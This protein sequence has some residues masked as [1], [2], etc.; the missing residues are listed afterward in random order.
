MECISSKSSTLSTSIYKFI[1]KNNA[2]KTYSTPYN[3]IRTSMVLFLVQRSMHFYD[4]DIGVYFFEYTLIWVNNIKL[5]DKIS[6]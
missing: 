1:P 6:K 5:K 3:F 4:I 2:K